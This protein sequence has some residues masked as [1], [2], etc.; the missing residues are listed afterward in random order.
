METKLSIVLKI[1]SEVENFE[2]EKERNQDENAK[3]PDDVNIKVQSKCWNS[4]W[5]A[6]K[7]KWAE[8]NVEL[9]QN[10]CYSHCSCVIRYA[11]YRVIVY[12]I[13]R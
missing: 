12:N 1:Q 7:L 3:A 9:L 6:C 5:M 11:I 2:G 13:S 4:N 10:E 8:S